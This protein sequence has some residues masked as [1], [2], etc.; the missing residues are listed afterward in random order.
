VNLYAG[1]GVAVR[2]FLLETGPANYLL[3]VDHKAVGVIEA[4]REGLTLT[5]VEL[6][7]ERYSEGVP[8][9]MPVAMRPLPFL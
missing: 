9:G 8:A 5:G 3:F 6:Q 1:R 7:T 2:E 4:K